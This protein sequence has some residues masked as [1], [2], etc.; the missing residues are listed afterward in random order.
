VASER[1]ECLR[2]G[3]VR[4]LAVCDRRRLSGDECRR[5]AYVGWAPSV[6]LDERQRRALRERV[7]GVR[8]FRLVG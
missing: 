1:I 7:P 3:A 2:C 6:D 5:C 4:V 8:H